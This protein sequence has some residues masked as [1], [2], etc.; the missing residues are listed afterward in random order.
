M[1]EIK[2]YNDKC[3]IVNNDHDQGLLPQ[4]YSEAVKN[5]LSYTVPSHEWSAKYKLGQ[6][7]G[8]I[9]LYNKRF[10]SFPSGLSNRISNLFQEL[11]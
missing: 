2:V 1:I 9:T 7:D 6:W 4:M 11:N 3:I 5:E 10:Q 8:K